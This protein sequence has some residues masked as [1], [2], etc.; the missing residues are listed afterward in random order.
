MVELTLPVVTMNN[1]DNLVASARQNP[2]VTLE[3]EFYCS[4]ETR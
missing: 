4:P 3:Q 2:D 1:L